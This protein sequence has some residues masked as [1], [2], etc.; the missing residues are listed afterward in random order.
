MF[1]TRSFSS[2]LA[3]LVCNR[4]SF[5]SLCIAKGRT[6]SLLASY[7]IKACFPC[8]GA[9]LLLVL[10]FPCFVFDLKSPP[11]PSTVPCRWAL[12]FH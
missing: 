5:S 11:I 10:F 12:A 7:T 3:A 8:H 2:L 9:P 4:S 6:S 1:C